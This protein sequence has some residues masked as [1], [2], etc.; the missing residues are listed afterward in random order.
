MKKLITYA[1]V[2]A[3][4]LSVGWFYYP[5]SLES[6]TEDMNKKHEAYIVSR[7]KVL[8][9]KLS[10]AEKCIKKTKFEEEFNECKYGFDGVKSVTNRLHELKPDKYDPWTA[11]YD[12]PWDLYYTY[13]EEEGVYISQ[14]PR[15]HYANNGLLATDVATGGRPLTMYAPDLK[16]EEVVYDVEYWS[17]YEELGIAMVLTHEKQRFIIG[18]VKSSL[19]TKKVKTGSAIGITLCPGDENSGITTGCHVH[20]MY[21]VNTNNDWQAAEYKVQK[22]YLKHEEWKQKR[23]LKKSKEQSG[24]IKFTTYNAEVGQTDSSPCNGAVANVCELYKEGKNPIAL[25]RDLIKAR[26]DF[27]ANNGYCIQNCPYEYG[28]TVIVHPENHYQGSFEAIIVDTMNI[29]YKNRGDLFK[30]DRS[31]NTS[32]WAKIEKL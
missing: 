18:H 6:L 13:L 12:K 19:E 1:I 8:L 11:R 26:S 31:K 10:L 30:D 5:K 20:I 21:Q 15:E 32:F 29:R 24:S 16:G 9:K 2:I 23:E 28:E 14:T 7:E 3:I 17:D 4:V 22:N 27:D 25:S